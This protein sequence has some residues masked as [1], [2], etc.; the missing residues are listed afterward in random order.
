M[1]VAIVS[2]HSEDLVLSPL[3]TVLDNPKGVKAAEALLVVS[4]DK[5]TDFKKQFP[6]G[7]CPLERLHRGPRNSSDCTLATEEESHTLA[8]GDGSQC[9]DSVVELEQMEESLHEEKKCDLGE[10]TQCLEQMKESLHEEKKDT[11][12]S[13]SDDAVED[14]EKLKVQEL[15]PLVR[16]RAVSGSLIR[17]SI[18]KI[19]PLEEIPVKE[20][21]FTW[22]QLPKPDMT[23]IRSRSVPCTNTQAATEAQVLRRA[24]GVVFHEVCIR[25]YEQTIGDN[26]SVSYGPPISLD[27]GYE[28]VEPITLD[29]YEKNRGPRRSTRQ[30]MLNYYNRKN[31]LTWRCGAT[32]DEMK[33]AEKEGNKIKGQRSITKAFLP[34]QKF[35]EVFQSIRR[36][37]KRMARGR[38]HTS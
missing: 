25:N 16:K 23:K 17:A 12:C 22:M 8:S 15:E 37:T 30:M 10:D 9:S 24:T 4:F 29:E 3:N 21:R 5:T 33:A 2:N 31:L 1:P 7:G 13:V 14:A 18:I 35:E 27:W 38:N 19:S 28:E 20:G 26:P 11:Q 34:A 36:K 6:T 32:E